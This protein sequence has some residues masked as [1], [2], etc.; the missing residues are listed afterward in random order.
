[1]AGVDF[2]KI[3]LLVLDVDGVLTDGRITLTASGAE[4]KT[5][6][7]RDGAGIKYFRRVGGKVAFITGRGSD[8]VVRRARELSVDAVRLNIKDKLPALRE[9]CRELGVPPERSAAV[10][11]D[12]TDLPILRE[13]G[14]SVAVADAAEEVRRAADHVTQ[15]PG[16]AGAV[17]EVIELILK[18]AGLWESVL[19]RYVGGATDPQGRRE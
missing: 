10:G 1:M 19:A 5:F 4:A 11:D 6:H 14:F 12:L 17:R 13:V 7:A 8:A 16:G 2:A 18:E 9:V 15:R 3:E